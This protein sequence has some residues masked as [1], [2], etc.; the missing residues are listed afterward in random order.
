[1]H[2]E[3]SQQTNRYISNSVADLDQGPGSSALL[4]PGSGIEKI[5]N[6]GKPSRIIFG[7]KILTFFVADPV[8]GSGSFFTLDLRSRIR[9]LGFWMEKFGSWIWD[10]HPGFATLI[11]ACPTFMPCLVSCIHYFCI[12]RACL[13][14]ANHAMMR[15][16]QQNTV[17]V[18]RA[19]TTPAFSL[20]VHSNITISNRI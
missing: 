20:Q 13:I 16:C 4:T 10:K 5:L 6:P 9:D 2:L 15:A 14:Q 19:S 17:Q 7:L 11:S 18:Q 8:P 12:M 3:L 1:M